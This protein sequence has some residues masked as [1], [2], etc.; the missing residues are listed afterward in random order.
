[1]APIIER[2]DSGCAG[3]PMRV[4]ICMTAPSQ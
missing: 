4:I 1:V 2:I 3:N